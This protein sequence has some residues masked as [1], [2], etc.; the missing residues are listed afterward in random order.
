MS[1]TNEINL[2]Y[3]DHLRGL[4]RAG[5][6]S[7]DNSAEHRSLRLRFGLW[8]RHLLNTVVVAGLRTLGLVLLS[9]IL[10]VWLRLF[11]LIKRDKPSEFTKQALACV[12]DFISQYPFHLYPVVCKAFELA[13]LRGQIADIVKRHRRFVEIAIGEGTLSSRVFPGDAIVVG[14]DLSP[15]SLKKASQKKH[16][17][18]AIVCDCLHPPMGEGSFDVLVANNFLHHVTH[19]EEILARWSRIAANAVFNENSPTWASG[20]PAPYLLRKIG[21]KNQAQRAANDIEKQSLQS[22]KPRSELDRYVS[23]SYDIVECVSYLSERTFFYCG[24]FSRLM[25]V[26]GPP[27]P[28]NLKRLFLTKMRWLAFPLSADIAKL[29]IRFDQHQDR[30][31]DAFIS[32]V[33]KS[34]NYLPGQHGNYLRCPECQRELDSI[35]RCAVCGKAYSSTDGM[36]FLLPQRLADLQEGYDS[37]LAAQLP[38]EH[39]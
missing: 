4:N 18:Q 20:W 38:A 36:L 28:A 21:R 34:R 35:N 12:D 10:E 14:L 27:T 31:T 33:C 15:Y 39:L 6:K 13:C 16:V 24:L 23:T 7:S 19:K 9:L 2:G 3:V 17:K 26:Y 29:L 25:R 8:R 5:A 22:L 1:N 11:L 30:S 32:Y 37:Q